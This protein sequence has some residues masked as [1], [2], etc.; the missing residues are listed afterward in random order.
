M[1]QVTLVYESNVTVTSRKPIEPKNGFV[2]IENLLVPAQKVDCVF[3]EESDYLITYPIIK[4]EVLFVDAVSFNEKGELQVDSFCANAVAGFKLLGHTIL[5]A[6]RQT[7]Y[8]GE[9]TMHS[10]GYREISEEA[11][12]RLN[13]MRCLYYVEGSNISGYADA[14]KIVVLYADRLEPRYFKV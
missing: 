11:Y 9:F 13:I 14:N 1:Y 2:K 4:T 6:S 12:N 3:M 5:E 10:D 8:E 7:L